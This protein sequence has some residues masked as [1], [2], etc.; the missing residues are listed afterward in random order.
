MHYIEEKITF[1]YS[2]AKVVLYHLDIDV[3]LQNIFLAMLL[4]KLCLSPIIYKYYKNRNQ[5]FVL[6]CSVS[7]H[8]KL[9]ICKSK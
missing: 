2:Y 3:H 8:K 1:P 9:L 5:V 7:C 6:Q 4:E